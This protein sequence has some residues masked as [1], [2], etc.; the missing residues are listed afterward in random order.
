MAE[1]ARRALVAVTRQDFA[2]DARKWGSWWTANEKRHR[3]EW[4][5][6]ALNHDVSDIRRAA[7]EELKALTKEYFGF[8]DDLPPRERER[9]QQRYRDWWVTE[10]RGR[11][12]RR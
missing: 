11:F 1:P 10:G 9:A 4:L 6:D 3:I 5:I 12:R 8:S 2:G 7:G